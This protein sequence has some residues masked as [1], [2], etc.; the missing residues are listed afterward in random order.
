MNMYKKGLVSVCWGISCPV[1][2]HCLFKDAFP[3]APEPAV[4]GTQAVFSPF[5]RFFPVSLP[6]W[7]QGGPASR[8]LE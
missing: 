5:I 6:D 3:P 2:L 1:F 7:Q 8:L 4:G